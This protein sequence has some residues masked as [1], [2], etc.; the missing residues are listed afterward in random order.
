MF[1]ENLLC[2]WSTK[3]CYVL[4]AICH[5][6]FEHLY[7]LFRTSYSYYID[8]CHP[9]IPKIKKGISLWNKQAKQQTFHVQLAAVI[10]I[11]AEI[12]HSANGSFWQ[13]IF[14]I[15][16]NISGKVWLPF[17]DSLFPVWT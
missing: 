14:D 6:L 7:V 11:Y 17:L 15:N 4:V 5:V 2:C 13:M 8:Q 12:Y 9:K 16:S 10:H 3:S 1:L